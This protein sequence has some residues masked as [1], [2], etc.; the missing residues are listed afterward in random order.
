MAEP[1][2]VHAH[3][4]FARTPDTLALAIATAPVLLALAAFVWINSGEHF[5]LP[6]AIPA[7][8]AIHAA[9]MAADRRR[10]AIRGH[11]DRAAMLGRAWS[12][13]PGIYLWRRARAWG[14]PNTGA[15]ARLWVLALGMS[16]ATFGLA[17]SPR[18]PGVDDFPAC[19]DALTATGLAS[20]Y[21][22]MTAPGGSVPRS[23]AG[24]IGRG[25]HDGRPLRYVLDRHGDEVVITVSRLVTR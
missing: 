8:M 15:L 22:R 7:V 5:P 17:L 2:A 18:A 12:W 21:E 9:L 4:N 14:T 16:S 1:L 25:D 19:A 23:C 6:L 20:V 10:L 13:V 11:G 24:V 3:S